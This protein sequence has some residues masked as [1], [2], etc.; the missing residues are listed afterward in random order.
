M[1]KANAP[2][3]SLS[4]GECSKCLTLSPGFY[5]QSR[6]DRHCQKFFGFSPKS[7]MKAMLEM[8]L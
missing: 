2:T 5:D 7:A 4:T 1:L 8:G 3:G 6:L